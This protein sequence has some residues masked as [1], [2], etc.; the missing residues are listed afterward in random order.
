MADPIYT[1]SI[2]GQQARVFPFPPN[3][4]TP[5]TETYEWK[6]EILRA[7]NGIEQRRR[8]RMSPRRSFEY[9]FAAAGEMA[10]MLESYLWAWH[11]DY[12][13]LPVWVDV[14]V[15]T[16]GVNIGDTVI[17]VGTAQLGFAPDEF[18]IIWYNPRLFEVV[19]IASVSTSGLVSKSGI[20]KTWPIGTRVFPLILAHLPGSV[21]TQRLTS[22]VLTGTV[23]FDSNPEFAPSDLP[24]TVAPTMYD[25]YEVVTASPNWKS[26]INNDFTRDFMTADSGIG[27][28]RYFQKEPTSRIVRPF[29]W[30]LRDRVAVSSFKAMIRRLAGQ[31]KPCWVPSWHGDFTLAAGA[32]AASNIIRVNGTWFDNSVNVD[33]SRDRVAIR[34]ASGQ[35]IYRR[36]VN[37]TPY[38]VNDTTEL[39][40]DSVL[41]TTVSS[42]DNVQ[43]LLHCRL[44]SDKVVIPWLTDRVANPTTNFTTIKL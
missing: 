8:L 1:Y 44:A 20:A 31:A 35:T 27:A 41:G 14:G 33:T 6:T 25:G 32:L 22:H 42:L 16:A 29:A 34:L 37:T 43:L 28:V 11:D 21:Q 38:Y 23:S 24:D 5:V 18:A 36:I 4:S 26:Q 19:E 2:H 30:T 40:L 3:W 10:S 15:L 17:P 39:Q 12:Y 13:A 7:F 9:S